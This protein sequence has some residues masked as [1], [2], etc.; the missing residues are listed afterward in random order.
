M[1]SL[2]RG[3]FCLL[4]L[5]RIVLQL[6][7]FNIDTYSMCEGWVVKWVWSHSEYWSWMET[8]LAY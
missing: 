1:K 4:I 2:W 6:W 3:K 7:M 5:G 8:V